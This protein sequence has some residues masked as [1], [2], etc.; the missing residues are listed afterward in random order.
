V[1]PV[2]LKS[3]AFYKNNYYIVLRHPTYTTVTKLAQNG[4]LIWEKSYPVQNLL[5]SVVLNNRIILISSHE[6]GLKLNYLDL[7]GREITSI[8]YLGIGKKAK[9][10]KTGYL[11]ILTTV[12]TDCISHLVIKR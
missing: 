3:L 7:N 11:Y 1:G 4:D 6:D 5:G 9:F 8:N 12:K 10:T 2:E